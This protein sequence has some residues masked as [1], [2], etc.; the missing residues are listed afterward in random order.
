MAT[1]PTT[2]ITTT[3]HIR[4]NMVTTDTMVIPT[5]TMATEGDGHLPR[6]VRGL[7]DMEAA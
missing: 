1:T 2:L 3:K 7:P 6:E 5:A 4:V